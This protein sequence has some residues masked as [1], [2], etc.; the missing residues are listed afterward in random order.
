MKL[1][2]IKLMIL[3]SSVSLVLKTPMSLGL[4]LMTQTITVIIF[5]NSVLYS[6]W[7]PMITFMMMIGGLLI[8]FMYMSSI[9]SNEK[10]K[11]K[12][13]LA[14]I[15]IIMFMINDEMMIETQINEIQEMETS[16]NLNF[17]LTSIF[18]NKSMLLTIMLVL[19]LLL[20]M[21]SITKMVKHHM[22][23]LR[24]MN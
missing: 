2:L 5:M 15:L 11:I 23:P 8:M 10:F 14:I 16:S 24:K 3:W 18:N 20:T 4:I 13:N 17:S 6:S 9:A 1:M 22:G 21:I 12:I 7:F 19:Y